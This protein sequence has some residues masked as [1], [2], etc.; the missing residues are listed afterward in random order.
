MEYI[1]NDDKYVGVRL[2]QYISLVDDDLT[3][4]FI[5]RL[6]EKEDVLVNNRASKSSYKLKYKDIVYIKEVEL[7]D[8]KLKAEDI[9]LEIIYEDDDILVVNKKKG[10]VVHP[11][12]G[13]HSG[14]MVN[15]LM[16]SHGN[17]L[18][19]ING[20]IRP[21]IVHR[22]DKNT[23]G[24]IVVAKNDNA[25]KKL[26][27]DFKSHNIKRKYSA[28]VNGIVNK[29]NLK[30]NLPIGRDNKDRKKM[31]VTNKNSKQA[32]TNIKVL[33]RFNKSGYTLIEATLETGRT[34]QIRVHMTYL[35]HSIIG[36]EVY[37]KV[38]NEFNIKGQMLHA[39]VLGINHPITGE[40]M[41]FK[42]KLPEEFEE[43][44]IKLRKKE[45]EGK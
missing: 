24:V 4:A 44:I 43:L 28:L 42:S 41:E 25:H 22:I 32:V 19:H 9:K 8:S 38:K 5:Q 16:F 21:G 20:V 7:E 10:M 15:A 6:I 39:K 13:N 35:G 31:A 14:T 23:S 18:S 37:G 11:G 17:N 2:D 33:E 36:D 30:I 3:R 40:Y 26:S 27:E 1:I 29:D 12:N 45:K 34:H